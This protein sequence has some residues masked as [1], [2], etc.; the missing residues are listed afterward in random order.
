[1]NA[2]KKSIFLKSESNPVYFTSQR[3]NASGSTGMNMNTRCETK[4]HDI[5]V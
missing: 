1:M 2:I 5:N 3:N 4:K